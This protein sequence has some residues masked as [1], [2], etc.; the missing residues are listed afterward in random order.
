MKTSSK[1]FAVLLKSLMPYS[2]SDVLVDCFV[3]HVTT[4]SD[5]LTR[6]NS[7][8][9]YHHIMGREDKVIAIIS[10]SRIKSLEDMFVW[11]VYAIS[12]NVQCVAAQCN[13]LAR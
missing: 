2:T 6:N 8:E 5:G 12:R 1:P 13:F 4:I 11:T 9:C 3:T 7:A 10:L